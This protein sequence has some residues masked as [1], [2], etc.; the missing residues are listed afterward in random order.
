[1]NPLWK[2]MSFSIIMQSEGRTSVQYK[3]LSYVN[4]PYDKLSGSGHR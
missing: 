2:Q 3:Y 1:M 4:K